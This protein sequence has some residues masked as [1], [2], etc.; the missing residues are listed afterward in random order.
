M[1]FSFYASIE[2]SVEIEY[3]DGARS[4]TDNTSEVYRVIVTTISNLC[5]SILKS[6]NLLQFV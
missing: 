3:F 6:F 2:L 1:S 5:L 4:N